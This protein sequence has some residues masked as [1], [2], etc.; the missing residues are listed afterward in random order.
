MSMLEIVDAEHLL[1]AWPSCSRRGGDAAK[2]AP[3]A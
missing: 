2:K 3:K 1:A